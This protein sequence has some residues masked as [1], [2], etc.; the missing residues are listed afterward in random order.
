M[1][2]LMGFQKHFSR[3]LKYANIEMVHRFNLH[4]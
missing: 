2:Q 1:Q 3:D 4:V